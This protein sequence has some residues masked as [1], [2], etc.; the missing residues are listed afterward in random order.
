MKIGV[1][2]NLEKPGT[3]EALARVAAAAQ[4]HQFTLCGDAETLAVLGTG[5]LC[6]PQDIGTDCDLALVLGGDGSMLHAAR[7]LAGSGVPQAGI[8]TGTLGFM[9]C[10]SVDRLEEVMQS[11][12]EGDY[13][14]DERRLLE[15]ELH[16]SGSNPMTRHALND[17]VVARGECARVVSL[18][19]A[20][21][22]RA[23]TTYLCD[24]L[25]VATPT[26]STAHSLSAGGPIVSPETP[27][28][29]ISVI[30][31]HTLTSRPLV[32]PDTSEIVL[33]VR[34]AA[35]PLL[36]SVDGQDTAR[37]SLGDRVLVRRSP[38]VARIVLLRDHDGFAVLR[39]KLGWRGSSV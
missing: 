28:V 1:L 3:A 10:A 27:A 22:G 11:L 8:N 23:V 16:V 15:A 21:D 17:V 7:L 39:S 18:E 37:F 6:L 5:T 25:I 29:V 34:R 19:L 13:Q 32:L 31:P 4:Q 24:G 14:V 2:A 38:H 9:T 35:A 30:C 33:T 26:G 12:A 36:V 20:V